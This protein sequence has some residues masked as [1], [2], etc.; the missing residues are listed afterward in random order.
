M[1][2]DSMLLLNQP[3]GEDARLEAD[4]TTGDV[5]L[6]PLHQISTMEVSEEEIFLKQGSSFRENVI[7]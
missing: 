4:E 3:A 5:C 2:F 7:K 1:Q 6:R